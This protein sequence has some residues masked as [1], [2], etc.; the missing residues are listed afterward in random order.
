VIV[1]PRELKQSEKPR[2]VYDIIERFMEGVPVYEA[3]ARYPQCVRD[4]YV[5]IG[6]EFPEDVAARIPEVDDH[7]I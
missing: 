5:S 6:N 1:T 4:D 2:I 7:D 3:Y